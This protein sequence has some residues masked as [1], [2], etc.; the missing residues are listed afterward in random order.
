MW[1]FSGWLTSQLRGLFCVGDF[2][3]LSEISSVVQAGME[4]TLDQTGQGLETILLYIRV[5]IYIHI[6]VCLYM[7]ISSTHSRLGQGIARLEK[8]SLGFDDN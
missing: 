7:Y 1:S 6:Y 2:L 8:D 5:Y 3:V 4:L